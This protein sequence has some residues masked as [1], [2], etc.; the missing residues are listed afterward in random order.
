MNKKKTIITVGVISIIGLALLVGLDQWTKQ[1]AVQHLAGQ[2]DII[3]IKDILVL[4]YLENTGAA[5]GLLKNKGWIF[6]VFTVIFL[7]FGGY[8]FVKTPK[9]KRYAPLHIIVVFLLA[10]AIGNL[11]DRVL[12]AYVIDFIYFVPINFPIFN[13][14]DMYVTVSAVILML[15]IGFYYKDEDFTFLNKQSEVPDNDMTETKEESDI[16]DKAETCDKETTR[17]N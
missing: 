5:F 6:I 4:Q 16:N 10:G 3:L 1:L 11:I 9:A 13:V 12:H 2:P 15:L 17:E 8:L 14:A 7:L